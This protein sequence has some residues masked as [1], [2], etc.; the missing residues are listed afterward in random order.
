MIVTFVAPAEPR[1]LEGSA[2]VQMALV[3]Y[4]NDDGDHLFLL[5]SSRRN[6]AAKRGTALSRRQ[7]RRCLRR[8]AAPTASKGTVF[9]TLGA[10]AEQP[11]APAF[12]GAPNI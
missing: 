7:R 9:R 6:F 2:E 4:A 5:P 1:T 11:A 10:D 3:H 8:D 12:L